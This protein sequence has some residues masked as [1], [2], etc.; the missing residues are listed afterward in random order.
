MYF[1]N[2]CDCI[3][4]FICCAKNQNN[5]IIRKKIE[6]E[7]DKKKLIF[8]DEQNKNYEINIER[9]FKI[10]K[11]ESDALVKSNINFCI[12]LSTSSTWSK[13]SYFQYV[14]LYLTNKSYKLEN[15]NFIKSIILDMWEYV[16]QEKKELAWLFSCILY[17]TNFF[18]KITLSQ[19]QFFGRGL[20]QLSSN[21]SNKFIKVIYINDIL[22]NCKD[23][24]EY[25]INE[26]FFKETAI[27]W[28]FLIKNKDKTWKTMNK[29]YIN[30]KWELRCEKESLNIFIENNDYRFDI[31]NDL[32]KL[33]N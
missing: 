5:P 16:S 33:F 29:S 23:S 2:I 6:N 17:N 18:K 32:I 27:F 1:S 11:E 14:F 10:L 9:Y 31:Y 15:V 8:C 20:L 12:N 22:H 24:F 28:K 4:Q 25:N 26:L 7:L 3:F 13:D 30:E 19:N 21:S